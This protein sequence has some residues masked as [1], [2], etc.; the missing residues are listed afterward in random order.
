MSR[1]KPASHLVPRTREGKAATLLWVVLFLLCMP[2]VTHAVLDRPDVWVAGVPFFFVA[3]LGVY[4]ALI[5]V[6]IWVQRR[7]I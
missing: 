3:L 4:S 6:L 5:A 1:E 7:G 2:P